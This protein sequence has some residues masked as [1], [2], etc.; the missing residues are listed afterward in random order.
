M[1]TVI[2]ISR[3]YGSQGHSIAERVA[4]RLNYPLV[5]RDLI[6]QAALRA[7][8]P[9]A[10][11]AAI[12]ELGLLGFCPSPEACLAYRQAVGQVMIELADK[13]EVVI[14]GRAGQV[15]LAGHP[16]VLHVRIIASTEKRVERVS[17]KLNIQLEAAKAQITT[18]DRFRRNY[19]K[20]FYQVDWNDP[21]LYDLV[22]NTDQVSEVQASEIIVATATTTVVDDTTHVKRR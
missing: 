13:G 18:S 3:Q 7:G 12:D 21:Y 9:E 14:V 17:H 15:I 4:A 1:K 8:A 2:T 5:W 22:I 11:L 16:N 19:L 6:N 10:A 20:R